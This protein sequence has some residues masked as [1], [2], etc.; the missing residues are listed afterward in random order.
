MIASDA[1]SGPESGSSL[2]SIMQA[3]ADHAPAIAAAVAAASPRMVPRLTL[4]PEEA[5]QALGVSRR[6]FYDHVL[7]ELRVV[8]RGRKVLIP[9]R[10]LERWAEQSAELT[11]AGR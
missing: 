6:F 11:L 4:S 5:A 3:I 8:R 9:L 2:G 1:R 7:P 10:E